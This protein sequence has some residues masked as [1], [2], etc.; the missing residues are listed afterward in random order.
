MQFAL[1]CRSRAD[2][3]SNSHYF[4]FSLAVQPHF[5]VR[6]PHF[7]MNTTM[8]RNDRPEL[9]SNMILRTT[10]QLTHMTTLHPVYLQ[11]GLL[12]LIYSPVLTTC[13]TP[14]AHGANDKTHPSFKKK[15]ELNVCY[16]TKSHGGPG[17]SRVVNKG[18]KIHS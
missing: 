2:S 1:K 15:K 17:G 12:H 16:R 5:T 4:S 7:E 8:F 3:S 6:L 18:L 13:P 11:N 10:T 14:T 9:N